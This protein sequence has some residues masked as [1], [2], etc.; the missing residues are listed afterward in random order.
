MPTRRITVGLALALV[1]GML[2]GL[3][4]SALAANAAQDDFEIHVVCDFLDDLQ[5]GGSTIGSISRVHPDLQKLGR[6]SIYWM[7]DTVEDGTFDFDMPVNRAALETYKQTGE[8]IPAAIQI[9]H[10]AGMEFY[11]QFKLFDQTIPVLYAHGV[12]LHWLQNPWRRGI[13]ALGGRWT[14][15]KTWVETHPQFLMARNM[16]GIR[17]G[18]E[19]EP[20]GTLKV[21]KNDAQATGI[22]Q[23][24]LQLYVS[25][26]NVIY[27]PYDKPYTSVMRSRSGRSW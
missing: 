17:D 14:W 8:F 20:I 11:V 18:I 19:R 13:S 27:R 16:T 6:K 4:S 2:T 10:E 5:W 15:S 26:D 23:G 21:I 1:L 12:P 22:H 7:A 3:A 25:T 24:N 9:A